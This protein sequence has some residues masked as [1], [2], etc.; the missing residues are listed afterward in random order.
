MASQLRGVVVPVEGGSVPS[1]LIELTAICT[2]AP[3]LSSSSGSEGPGM[4][5]VHFIQ[6]QPKHSYTSN[7]R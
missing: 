4:H 5:A 7:T 3:G 2:P 1:T 6:V